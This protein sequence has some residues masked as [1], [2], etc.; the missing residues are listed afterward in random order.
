MNQTSEQINHN[1]ED[2]FVHGFIYCGL[3]DRNSKDIMINDI[4]MGDFIANTSRPK[5]K[6]NIKNFKYAMVMWDASRAGF[7]LFAHEDYEV[8]LFNSSEVTSP[9]NL[10]VVG[11]SSDGSD[12]LLLENG[13]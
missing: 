4:V 13:L 2:L 3:K 7:V 6:K 11:N 10:V 5:K 9:E 1:Q 8:M 12:K